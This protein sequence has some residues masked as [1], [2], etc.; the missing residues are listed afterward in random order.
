MN[1]AQ[2]EEL[3][4]N[5]EQRDAFPERMRLQVG[6][7]DY[8]QIEGLCQLALTL[9]TDNLS[10]L[11]HLLFGSKTEMTDRVCGGAGPGANIRTAAQRPRPVRS[12]SVRGAL[13]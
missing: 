2:L 7:W 13:D 5:Q 3:T 6:P 11:R 10:K 1:C 8:R 9:G 4:L 12:G